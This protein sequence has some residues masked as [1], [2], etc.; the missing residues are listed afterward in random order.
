LTVTRFKYDNNDNDL[1]ALILSSTKAT[2]CDMEEYN[3]KCK[4]R[5]VRTTF[6]KSRSDLSDLE[7]F[8]SKKK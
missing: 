2:N 5:H 6:T 1:F 3:S 8:V 4:V 7:L